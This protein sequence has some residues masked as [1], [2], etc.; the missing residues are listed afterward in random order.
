MFLKLVLPNKFK[1]WLVSFS[2]CLTRFHN[3]I[4]K[5]ECI[6]KKTNKNALPVSDVLSLEEGFWGDEFEFVRDW[7]AFKGDEGVFEEVGC[8]L[9]GLRALEVD[10]RGSKVFGRASEEDGR[11]ISGELQAVSS[12]FFQLPSSGRYAAPLTP[13]IFNLE[14]EEKY[15]S[16]IN[17]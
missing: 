6:L 17:H 10:S 15:I 9:E 11:P 16:L 2:I 1:Q 14:V 8:E 4:P 3:E 5:V 7:E 12:G 13:F